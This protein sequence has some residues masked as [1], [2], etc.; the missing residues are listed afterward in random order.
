MVIDTSS[1]LF[2]L[3]IFMWMQSD[4]GCR[5]PACCAPTFPTNVATTVSEPS[6]V[7][8]GSA[9]R[10]RGAGPNTTC[11]LCRGSNSE[12]WQKH[13]NT[14]LSSAA[15]FNQP[16]MGHPACEQIAE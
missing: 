16:V 3:G 2:L 11:A 14:S 10:R 13:L 9:A 12:L 8:S 5:Y 15:P 7:V 1:I 4:A 6:V